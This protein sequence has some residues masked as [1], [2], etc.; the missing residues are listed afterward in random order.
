MGPCKFRGSGRFGNLFSFLIDCYVFIYFWGLPSAFLP[1]S[2]M[3]KDVSCFS[4][5][6][7]FPWWWLEEVTNKFPPECTG[8]EDWAHICHKH[9]LW[10]GSEEPS[11]GTNS[12]KREWSDSSHT[13]T[14][15]ETGF[16]TVVKCTISFSSLNL[17][18]LLFSCT[19]FCIIY[20]HTVGTMI[21]A[22]RVFH[23]SVYIPGNVERKV[24][25]HFSC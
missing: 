20:Q 16:R 13:S 18:F 7:L 19:Y 9:Q 1:Q 10:A 2:F 25:Y 15:K 14:T 12:R 4:W 23:A 5:V 6:A 8:S 17:L 11:K 22:W 21:W 3:D 24:F